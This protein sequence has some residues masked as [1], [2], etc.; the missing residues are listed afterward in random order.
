MKTLAKRLHGLLLSAT[1]L[2]ATAL[3]ATS[4]PAAAAPPDPSR[5]PIL[6]EKQLGSL[7][8][9][10]RLLGQ[11]DD[12]WN[13]W[14]MP[15]DMR[16]ADDHVR[17]QMGFMSFGLYTAVHS[18]TPAYREL[19]ERAS[20][21]MIRKMFNFIAWN[22]MVPWRSLPY[23]AKGETVP[24][25]FFDPTEDFIMYTG[26]LYPM[27]VTHQMLFND[28]HYSQ[29]KSIKFQY[30][31]TN[32]APADWSGLPGPTYTYDL[33]SLTQRI[34][35][36][37][38]KNDWKGV[39]CLPNALFV[40][41]N[42]QPILGFKMYD[43]VH[44]TDYFTKLSGHYKRV[45]EEDKLLDDK[46]KTWAAH[47][48]IGTKDAKW[49]Y[50]TDKMHA[51]TYDGWAGLTAHA[52]NK[53]PVEKAYA[54]QVARDLVT[55]PDG[56]ATTWLDEKET[57]KSRAEMKSGDP[58]TIYSEGHSLLAAFVAEMGDAATKAK[59]LNYADK[60]YSPKWDGDSY[61]YPISSTFKRPGDPA[62]VWRRVQPLAANGTLPTAWLLQKDG[63]YNL[64]NHP[65]TAK[66]FE[67]PYLSNVAYPQVQVPRA[68]Y[69][70]RAKALIVTLRPSRSAASS[71]VQSWTFNNLDSKQNWG[72]WQDGRKI[73][74]LQSGVV[75]PAS[76]V[77]GFEA[78]GTALKVSMPVRKE[79]TFI[80]AQ[81]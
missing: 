37:F 19:G 1:I 57:K 10:V 38:E 42:Q 44:G 62:N 78:Q 69:D 16:G 17:Y 14:L 22:D 18:Y 27:L 49:E 13:G 5:Y 24:Y 40:I 20:S 25:G 35:S 58:A 63:L 36:N 47:Y 33:A 74:M 61:Y 71:E 11:P 8:H 23:Q 65:F 56:T 30:P 50:A 52:W 70:E 80:V 53:E 60:Y 12:D 45:W 68:V 26:H 32:G 4:V 73:A 9:I 34:Y 15:A 6:D 72:V 54:A 51:P 59:L 28:R 55:L 31:A 7:N 64:Y 21:N 77:T 81:E 3:M 79:T 76:G 41:C 48:L 2:G 29:P 75:K 66:D 43:N 39:E 46:T 67:E